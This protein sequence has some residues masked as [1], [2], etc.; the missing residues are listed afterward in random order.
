[1]GCNVINSFAM[2]GDISISAQSTVRGDSFTIFAS[3]EGWGSKS[4]KLCKLEKLMGFLGKE[5]KEALFEE[6]FMG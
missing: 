3:M 6:R 4:R 5:A 2:C 1:M